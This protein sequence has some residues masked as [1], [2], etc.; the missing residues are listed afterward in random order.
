MSFSSD[1][2]VHFYAHQGVADLTAKDRLGS[3][4]CYGF[5]AE[6]FHSVFFNICNI[7]N[8]KNWSTPWVVD[9]PTVYYTRR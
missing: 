8:G 6:T 4:Y 9:D 5:R 7:D 2:Q 3:Y 1:G